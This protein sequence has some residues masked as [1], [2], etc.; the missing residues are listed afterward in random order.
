MASWLTR[1]IQ[2]FRMKFSKLSAIPTST[3][4]VTSNAPLFGQE[5]GDICQGPFRTSSGSFVGEIVPTLLLNGHNYKSQL[6]YSNNYH[7]CAAGP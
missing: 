1:P 7:A 5:I 3:L 4:T 6:M 2:C